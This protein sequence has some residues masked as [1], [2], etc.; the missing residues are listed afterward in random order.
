MIVSLGINFVGHVN[1]NNNHYL[2]LYSF[3]GLFRVPGVTKEFQQFQQGNS[4][5]MNLGK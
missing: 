3:L 2:Y 4:I 1:N 5:D